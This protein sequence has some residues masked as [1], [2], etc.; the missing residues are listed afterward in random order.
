[1]PVS[2]SRKTRSRQHAPGISDARRRRQL[3]D[4]SLYCSVSRPSSASAAFWYPV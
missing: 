3:L 2:A 1:M 4:E